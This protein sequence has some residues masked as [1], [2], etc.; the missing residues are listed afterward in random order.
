MPPPQMSLPWLRT[1]DSSQYSQWPADVSLS[2]GSEGP[3]WTVWALQTF[4]VLNGILQNMRGSIQHL[5]IP[6]LCFLTTKMNGSRSSSPQTLKYT[7]GDNTH[8]YHSRLKSSV[9]QKQCLIS[10]DVSVREPRRKMKTV[11]DMQSLL[12]TVNNEGTLLI[13]DRTQVKEMRRQWGEGGSHPHSPQ[14]RL[15]PEAFLW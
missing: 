1:E 10:G 5:W 15:T 8:S 2:H 11:F 3:L 13:R 12:G 6:T 4:C 14:L 9:W 7:W